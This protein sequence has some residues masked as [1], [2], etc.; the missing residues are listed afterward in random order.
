MMKNPRANLLDYWSSNPQDVCPFIDGIIKY[1][2]FITYLTNLT[3]YHRPSTTKEQPPDEEAEEQYEEEL[4]DE[5]EL[6]I[7]SE[8]TESEDISI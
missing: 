2:A 1:P 7:E 4:A 8:P 3:F 5:D 6:Y